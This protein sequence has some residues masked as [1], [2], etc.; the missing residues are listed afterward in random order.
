MSKRLLFGAADGKSKSRTQILL[1]F[2]LVSIF[3]P[4]K[5]LCERARETMLLKGFRASST[6]VSQTSSKPRMKGLIRM[7]EPKEHPGHDH[8]EGDP[9]KEPS[10]ILKYF[11]YKHLPSQLASVSRV[12]AE[13]A[14][15]MEVELTPGRQKQMALEHLLMAKDAAVRSAL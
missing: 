9:M 14:W 3:P 11:V 12:F 13:I 6:L 10:E 5:V 2:T 4:L 8:P 7:P 1:K 15:Q